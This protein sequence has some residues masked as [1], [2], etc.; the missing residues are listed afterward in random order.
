MSNPLETPLPFGTHRHLRIDPRLKQAVADEAAAGTLAKSG[1]KIVGALRRFRHGKL[2]RGE[3]NV[4][5]GNR[6]MSEGA[7][8]DFASRV[9][10]MHMLE[11]RSTSLALDATRFHG[12]NCLYVAVQDGSTGY[13][14]WAQPMAPPKSEF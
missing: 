9:E 14:G 1:S 11:F 8:K 4:N 12:L 13:C 10:A 7:A 3:W 5:V 6:W 2:S